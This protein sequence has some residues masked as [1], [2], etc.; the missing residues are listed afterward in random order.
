MDIPKPD[1]SRGPLGIPTVADRVVQIVI[2]NRL[3][4]YLEPHF[5]TSSYGCCQR[6]SAIQALQSCRK[7]G[8]THIWGGSILTSKGTLIHRIM[9]ALHLFTKDRV[10]LLYCERWLKSS[11]PMPDGTSQAG[12]EG[13]PQG[14][15]IR[16]LLVNLYLVLLL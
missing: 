9:Q 3:E 2:K 11:V 8:W 15:V 4:S 14:G 5:H 10:I 7:N 1:G 16:P 12:T 6:K 13:T